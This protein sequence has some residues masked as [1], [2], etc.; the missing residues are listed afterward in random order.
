MFST[1]RDQIL[2]DIRNL[3]GD[4]SVTKQKTKDALM[5]I[6]ELAAELAATIDPEED[7]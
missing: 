7:E 6:S 1:N 5:D 4:T 2:E 3:L